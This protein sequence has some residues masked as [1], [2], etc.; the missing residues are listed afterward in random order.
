MTEATDLFI[1]KRNADGR[2]SLENVHPNQLDA[3]PGAAEG[4]PSRWNTVRALRVFNWYSA[5]G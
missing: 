3:E 1:S 2:W 5:R 4:R